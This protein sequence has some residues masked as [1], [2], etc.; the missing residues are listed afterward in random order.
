MLGLDVDAAGAVAQALQQVRNAI[1]RRGVEDP[2]LEVLVGGGLGGREP[3]PHGVDRRLAGQE[4]LLE[5]GVADAQGALV[6]ALAVHELLVVLRG[7]GEALLEGDLTGPAVR[8]PPRV[9][10]EHLGRGEDRE[11]VAGNPFAAGDD[12]RDPRRLQRLAGGREL[13]PGR[14]RIA[15][16]GL[17][18]QRL[19]VEQQPLRLD[20][21]GQAVQHALVA[22]GIQVA[23]AREVRVVVGQRPQDAGVREHVDGDVGHQVGHVAGG[24]PRLDEVVGGRRD[25]GVGLD[26]LDGDVGVLGHERVRDLLPELQA[27]VGG[28]PHLPRDLLGRVGVFLA[29]GKAGGGA[30]QACAQEQ[31]QSFRHQVSPRKWSAQRGTPGTVPGRPLSVASTVHH[32]PATWPARR[33]SHRPAIFDRIADRPLIVR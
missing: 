14:R 20:R 32:E 17:R 29:R 13:V 5:V 15:Q 3:A 11:C 8:V 25:G 19:V 21:R 7:L 4:L 22:R 2:H 33:R 9:V 6:E 24:D 23:D 26:Q 1:R 27:Q 12:G 16:S 28:H 10:V 30:E 31:C 18:P